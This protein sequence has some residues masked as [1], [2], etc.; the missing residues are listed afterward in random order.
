MNN[1]LNNPLVSVIMPAYNREQSLPGSIQSILDQTYKN[2]ELLIID[3]RS[4]D[5]T[6]DV[7]EKYSQKDGR[8]KYLRNEYT[9]GPAGAR[10][11][12][13]ANSLGKYIS[14]LDSDDLWLSHHLTDS[15]AI[16]E[17]E[18]LSFCSAKLFEKKGESIKRSMF[19]GSI[20]YIINRFRADN[21]R[22]NYYI[23]DPSI[24]EFI[25]IRN[26]YPY[27]ISTVVIE[28]SA[29]KK[30]GKFDED[31]FGPEDSDMIF[32]IS[33]KYGLC[34]ID[35]FHS[36]WVEGKDNIHFFKEDPSQFENNVLPKINNNRLNAIKCFIKNKRTIKKNKEKFIN[37]KYAR[38]LMNYE[39]LRN[40]L[41]LSN[42]NKKGNFKLHLKVIFKAWY[43]SLITSKQLLKQNAY[44][45][46]N[47]HR[48]R[49]LT[50]GLFRIEI[51][52]ISS[53]DPIYQE[54]L[55]Q[56]IS[57][58]RKNYWLYFERD[59]K[60]EIR[61][62]VLT[63]YNYKTKE[64]LEIKNI[65]SELD[66]LKNTHVL[67]NHVQFQNKNFSNFIHKIVKTN[68]GGLVDVTKTGKNP[69]PLF[70][71]IELPAIWI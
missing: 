51:S 59:I 24:C 62:E 55:L 12:G 11:F 60:F 57:S 41:Y 8:I 56:Q 30:I 6:K 39:I 5:K 40:L 50:E 1:F 19:V 21:N 53:H 63:L 22:S 65:L 28:K 2:W 64:R 37:Y 36:I 61:D 67:V 20:D 70:K 68:F 43:Y 23:F 34:I 66:Y 16:L 26:I 18:K 25:L 9:Q 48:T 29:L 31:L 15:I 13:I 4:M 35:N 45:F 27:H 69:V 42:L 17:K 32:R 71:E 58:E 46:A 44:K 38:Q 47:R 10:N 33:L 14:F 3:D 49:V 54:P 52:E 7:I